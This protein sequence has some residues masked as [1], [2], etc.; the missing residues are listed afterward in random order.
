MTDSSQRETRQPADSSLVVSVVM[1]CLNEADTV[2]Q[3]VRVAVAT[4]T[5]ASIPGEVIVADNGSTDSSREVAAAAGARVVDVSERGYGSALMGGFA[6]SKGRYIVMGD[7]D[8]S[9]DFGEMPRF[10]ERLE[11]GFDIVLGCRL[12]EGGGQILPGAMPA[13]HRWLG[14]PMFSVLA[15]RWFNAP[16]HDIYCGLRGFSAAAYRRLD[17]RCTGMEFATEMVIKASLLGL[18]ISEI[19][20]VLA[21]DGRRAHAPHLKTFRDGWKTLRFFLLCT[22]IRLFVVPGMILVGLG[23]LAVALALPGVTIRGVAFDAHTLLFG[24]LALISGYQCL[25]FSVHATSFAVSEGLLPE[26]EWLRSL[27][28]RLRPEI[29][30]SLGL[31]AMMLG[32]TLLAAAVWVW[33]GRHF[34]RLD[35]AETM[36]LVVPGV[37][38]VTLG[39]QTVLSSFLTSLFGLRRR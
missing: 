26:V 39:F 34:G 29:W 14:N 4:L 15:R 11:E 22:P 27:N 31:L 36:R 33:W 12:P 24:S 13:L 32:G 3:C 18:R 30:V 1:P 23:S 28:S 2:G 37:T 17:L 19:P 10:V 20:V 25:L 7:A 5:N 38:F 9:Y 8:A 16:V 21:P 35:Y 6:A